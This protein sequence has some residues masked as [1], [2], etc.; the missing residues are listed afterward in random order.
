MKYDTWTVDT[1]STVS[2][3]ITHIHRGKI[4]I[5]IS[6][7]GQSMNLHFLSG[8]KYEFTFYD[9]NTLTPM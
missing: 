8:A 2:H 9:I 3:G 1:A 5:H 7:A 4:I 6:L